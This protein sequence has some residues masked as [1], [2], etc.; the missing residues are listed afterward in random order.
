LELSEKESFVTAFVR[1][2]HEIAGFFIIES[3]ISQR[4]PLSS[5]AFV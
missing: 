5:A 3:T 4:T 1:Y 2:F